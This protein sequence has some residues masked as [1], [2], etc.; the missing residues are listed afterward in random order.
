MFQ[1]RSDMETKVFIERVKNIFNLGKQLFC[2]TYTFGSKEDESTV[3]IDGKDENALKLAVEQK[4]L[5]S[6]A[7]SRWEEGG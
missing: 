5:P 1:V 4:L 7:V 6:T 3:E 2:V